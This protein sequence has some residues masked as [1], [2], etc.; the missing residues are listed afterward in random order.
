M[1]KDADCPSG[2]GSSDYDY[3][4]GYGYGRHYQATTRRTAIFWRY[5][6]Y[7]QHE[8]LQ[9]LERALSY[10]GCRLVKTSHYDAWR[11]WGY[12]YHVEYEV[13]GSYNQIAWFKSYIDSTING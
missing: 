13:E 10:S 5:G 4:S 12:A 3:S 9:L 11:N 7:R 2:S 6:P 1:A 8:A